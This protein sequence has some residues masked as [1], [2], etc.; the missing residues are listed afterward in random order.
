MKNIN[1][2][3]ASLK[4]AVE[5]INLYKEVGYKSEDE[6]N[7]IKDFISDMYDVH[8]VEENGAFK[9]VANVHIEYDDDAEYDAYLRSQGYESY[10]DP[11]DEPWWRR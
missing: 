10:D 8:F 11:K 1:K 7:T 4:K 9:A 5:V 2:R 6:M 3:M